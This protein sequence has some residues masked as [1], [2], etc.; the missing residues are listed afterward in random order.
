MLFLVLSTGNDMVTLGQ[1]CQTYLSVCVEQLPAL[2]GR[3][4]EHCV[5]GLF[6]FQ[7]N[8]DTGDKNQTALISVPNPP[9]P[10]H[11]TLESDESLRFNPT[12]RR[13]DTASKHG[14]G[15]WM[16]LGLPHATKAWTAKATKVLRN[17]PKGTPIVDLTQLMMNADSGLG[18]TRVSQ[19]NAAPRSYLDDD[20]LHE[21][22]LYDAGF[23][24]GMKQMYDYPT[25]HVPGQYQATPSGERGCGARTEKA[26]WTPPNHHR[27]HL[28]RRR[29]AVIAA[30]CSWNTPHGPA[31]FTR[32]FLPHCR[33]HCLPQRTLR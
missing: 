23:E 12:R 26:Y 25:A 1:A 29:S 15:T 2:T 21:R 28:R 30:A 22:Q 3:S 14:I 19:R 8:D 32:S 16:P 7:R 6:A 20:A 33:L 27:H 31:F 17:A 4:A 5:R 10:P 24:I 13:H 18:N 11:K 9:P